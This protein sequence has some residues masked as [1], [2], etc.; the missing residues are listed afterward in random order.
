MSLYNIE[1]ELLRIFAEIEENDGEIS[2]ETYAQ[3]NITKENLNVKLDNYVKYIISLDGD[4]DV[5]KKEVKRLQAKAKT[6]E[7]RITQLKK[8]M[9]GAVQMFGTEGKTN[10]FIDLPTVRLFT[11]GSQSVETNDARIRILIG[12]FERYVREL[13]DNG[14]L[15]TGQDVELQGILDSVNANLKAEHDAQN[16]EVLGLE[17][18]GEFIPYT[19]SD[20]TTL[21][22]EITTTQSIYDLFRTG[23]DALI[24]YAKNP[25][26][27]SMRDHTAK[28]DWKSVIVTAD[29]INNTEGN[30]KQF[31]YPSVAKIV[32][33]ESI[34]MK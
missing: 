21:K 34:Q 3:L 18:K 27:T 23:K 1:E 26:N 17:L 28:D 30:D 22:I 8:A 6:K 5:V 10:K 19:L 25:I 12:E 16:T 4:V 32:K 13:V 33:N 11:K 24:L 2:D 20:L 15:Y 9:L 7:T 31:S 29:T 14:V